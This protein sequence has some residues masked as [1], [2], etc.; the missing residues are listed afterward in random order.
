ML[1]SKFVKVEACNPNVRA[2]A[3]GALLYKNPL[4]FQGDFLLDL[5]IFI[6]YNIKQ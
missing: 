5:N 3:C 1:E 6:S 4:N 2:N